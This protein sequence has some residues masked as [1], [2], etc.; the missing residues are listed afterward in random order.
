MSDCSKLDKRTKKYKDCIEAE[1]QAE[2]AEAKAD[3][4][5]RNAAVEAD[6]LE[7]YNPEVKRTGLKP[8]KTEKAEVKVGAGD[9]VEKAA[10]ALKI[11]KLMPKDKD[12]GCQDRKVRY[13]FI[14]VGKT[15]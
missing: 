5:A 3:G 9:I 15:H 7:D 14:T 4:L 1:K 11:D 6:N 10:K 12:C 8:L 13:N 2:A